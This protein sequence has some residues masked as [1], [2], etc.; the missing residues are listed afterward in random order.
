MK[1]VARHLAMTS[2]LALLCSC[3]QGLSKRHATPAPSLNRSPNMQS[4][5]DHIAQTYA[6]WPD[7]GP[8]HQDA[9]LTL[10][11][12][13]LDVQVGDSIAVWHV[14]EAVSPGRELYIMG[15]KPVP[16]EY[17]D[18]EL[19][20]TSVPEG[21]AYPWQ[22]LYDG[23]VLPSPGID[24]HWEPSTYTFDKPG[25][26]SIQWKVNGLESNTLVIKVM[27]K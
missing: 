22:R 6:T 12:L 7:K 2:L 23:A 18:G 9:R 14:Y 8:L 5:S 16:G 1:G 4:S 26:H 17:L 27:D 10:V 13:R 24:T 20:T 3:Q 21:W 25:T 15:P 11:S 19:R